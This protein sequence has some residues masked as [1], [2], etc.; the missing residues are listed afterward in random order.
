[1]YG[2]EKKVWRE[3]DIRREKY[4]RFE[5]YLIERIRKKK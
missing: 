4:S 3:K 5:Y 2:Y 1:M